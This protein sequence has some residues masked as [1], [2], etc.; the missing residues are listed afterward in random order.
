[1]NIHLPLKTVFASK[2]S[3]IIMGAVVA[4]L[5]SAGS[6]LATANPLDTSIQSSSQEVLGVNNGPSVLEIS[7][8]DTQKTITS[9]PLEANHSFNAIAPMWEETRA[10][11]Q[12]R[13]V[14]IRVSS[15]GRDW[16]RWMEIDAVKSVRD[17]DPMA[18][19]T[20][21]ETP[22][23]VTGSHFQYRVT[24]Q[25]NSPD[26]ASPKI[27]DMKMTYLDSR[28]SGIQKATEAVSSLGKKVFAANG[29]PDIVTRSE[30]DSPDPNGD[31]FQGDSPYWPPTYND[32]EQVFLH[33]TVHS[34]QQSNPEEVVR[35]I[36]DYHAK[37][38]G[39][40]DIGYNYLLDHEGAIYE[41]R[42]GGDHVRAG[43]V[44]DYNKGSMGVAVLGCFQ[45]D[46]STCQE[47]NDGNVTPPT[48]ATLD[49]LSTL[50]SWKTTSFEIDPQA[51][52]QFCDENGNNC[53]NLPTIAAHR[54]AGNTTCNGDLFYDKMD[55]IRQ[56]T[57]NKNSN[58]PW[59]YAARL[60]N[61]RVVD[62][63]GD[64]SSQVTMEFKNTGSET[65]SNST[66]RMLLKTDSP[67]GEGSDFQGGDWLDSQTPAELNENSVDPGQTGSFTFT[68]SRPS[69]A[70][71]RY[72][73]GLR[74]VSENNVTFN[75]HY[76]AHLKVFCSFGYADN[77]RPN[78]TMIRN[79]NNGKIFLIENG[80]I[81][82]LTSPLAIKSNRLNSRKVVNVT[83]RELSNLS[84]GDAIKIG[85]G[86]LIKQKS[87]NK[88]F[89]ID[90]TS[91]GYVKR[92]ISGP[93]AY[94]T[95]DLDDAPTYQASQRRLDTYSDGPAVYASSD[96]PDGLVFTSSETHRIFRA[97]DSQKRYITHPKV[98]KSYGYEPKRDIRRV[99]QGK[100]DALTSGN[101][102]STLRTG[103]TVTTD[104]S[105]KVFAIDT[106]GTTDVRR[107]IVTSR[108]YTKAG[109]RWKD[110]MTIGSGM[111]DAYDSGETVAC[112]K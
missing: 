98:F 76:G 71:G 41:G 70:F 101:A 5:L 91:S 40:G 21:M 17:N 36:W 8:R 55:N 48:D 57:A 75:N 23:F 94:R 14:E 112:H 89:I 104:N 52:H 42:Y 86:T 43:H 67:R 47:L 106:D 108:S 82:H 99:S 58:N 69:D 6:Y 18:G 50:L 45:S 90:K 12:N 72:Y 66:N 93:K 61:F 92:H 65:W 83:S 35:A 87:G 11:N 73:E 33:H 37:T 25:R 46:N 16:T 7:G 102:L 59:G 26:E 95:F 97:E 80:K 60:T 100:I 10:D 78:G 56:D 27:T 2:K 54:D 63:S 3:K 105:P 77:P 53:L 19:T 96:I 49:S 38:L 111:L 85:E 79:P 24:L 15:D 68:W 31:K 62:L 34:N 29:G 51:T 74:L 84:D 64:R 109:F 39:W 22:I 30:W 28:K 20:Y 9:Q 103:T 1:M 44:S 13:T 88:I 32:T 4:V 107:H 81:R 110:V